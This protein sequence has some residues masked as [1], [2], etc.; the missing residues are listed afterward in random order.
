MIRSRL[1]K[2]EE[3]QRSLTKSET[4]SIRSKENKKVNNHKEKEERLVGSR[5]DLGRLQEVTR[6]GTRS[7][8]RVGESL[9]KLI[10]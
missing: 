3:G 2:R 5:R 9:I 4:S 10:R 8:E 7:D 1:R 6:E